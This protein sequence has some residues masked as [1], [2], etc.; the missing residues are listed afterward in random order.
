MGIVRHAHNLYGK[1]EDRRFTQYFGMNIGVKGIVWKNVGWI[2]LAQV[3]DQWR[4]L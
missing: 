4:V 2:H 3:W 1:A